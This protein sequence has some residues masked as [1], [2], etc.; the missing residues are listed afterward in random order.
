[1]G[2]H[3]GF[4]IIK[5]R[6]SMTIMLGLLLIIFGVYVIVGLVFFTV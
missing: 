6:P 1:M 5:R 4:L 3:L 2:I